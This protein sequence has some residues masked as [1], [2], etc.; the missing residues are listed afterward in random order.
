M[1]TDRTAVVPSR[2]PHHHKSG[3]PIR[4]EPN[5][6]KHCQTVS[7]FCDGNLISRNDSFRREWRRIRRWRCEREKRLANNKYPRFLLSLWY[8][9]FFSP[10]DFGREQINSHSVRMYFRSNFRFEWTERSEMQSLFPNQFISNRTI[11]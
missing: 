1:D 11:D 8:M 10:S 6:T 4:T 3:A 9:V 7:S 2:R 5:Q